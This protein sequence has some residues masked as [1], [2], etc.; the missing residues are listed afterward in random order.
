MKKFIVSMLVLAMASLASAGIIDISNLQDIKVVGD[1]VT[2]SAITIITFTGDLV[3]DASVAVTRPGTTAAGIVYDYSDWTTAE[4][5]DPVLMAD[6]LIPGSPLPAMPLG[7]VM[8]EGMKYV[9]GTGDMQL[10]VESVYLA[11]GTPY[12]TA[13]IPEPATM[14]LLSLGGLLLRRK[15]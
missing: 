9:G 5:G 12:A 14:V 11:S 8:L 3:M 1:D 13:T 10:F 15:K 6:M 2:P 4:S 7:T